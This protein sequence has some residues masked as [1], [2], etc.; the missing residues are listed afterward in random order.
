[1]HG[2][3]SGSC[4]RPRRGP[5]AAA[6]RRRGHAGGSALTRGEHK[7]EEDSF[8]VLHG[9]YWLTASIA[10]RAPVLLAVDDLHWADQPSLRFIG[11]LARRLEGLPVALVLTVREPRA[12]TPQDKAL[13]AGLAAEPGVTV[14]RPAA[15]GRA[16]CAELVRGSARESTRRRRSRMPAASS[17]EETRSCCRRC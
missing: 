1:M 10:Q 16:A 3:W 12:G 8:A 5:T 17:P 15:L 13:T 11:H 6:A 4:S 14:V 9:L 2:V 7:V